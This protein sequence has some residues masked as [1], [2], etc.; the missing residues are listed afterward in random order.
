MNKSAKKY[1]NI[2]FICISVTYLYFISG[3]ASREAKPIIL[4]D[5]TL[6]YPST[7][8]K[9]NFNGILLANK[10]SK[11]TSKPIKQ[12]TIF[13][14]DEKAK[15]YAVIPNDFS[16]DKTL[17]FHIDWI[18]PGGNSFYRKQIDISPEDSI[19]KLMSSISLSPQKRS[20]GYYTVRLY[21]FRELI[22]EKN[23]RL[24]DS[25]NYFKTVKDDIKLKVKQSA[26]KESKKEIQKIK[27]VPE[28]IS[29]DILLCKKISEKTGKPIGAGIEFTIK[30][31]AKVK[32]VV[33]FN[34][35]DVKTNEQMK[36]YFE[37]IGPDGKSFYKKRIV[38]TTSSPTFTLTN[39]ISISPEK[40]IPGIYEVRIIYK[41]KIIAEK[42]FELT[43]QA[44]QK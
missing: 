32:A 27:K 28:K 26:T 38:Y 35:Q 1:F 29:A 10:I 9:E 20:Q 22:A 37:W 25:T 19:D 39:S 41:K 21:L 6:Y 18:D 40:R 36:F 16:K 42:K 8:E 11:K 7:F 4:N 14:L 12:G 5:S 30:E 23:F 17:M 43:D 2:I 15:L 3:C 31:K 24:L 44:Q 33:S 13:K 34:K